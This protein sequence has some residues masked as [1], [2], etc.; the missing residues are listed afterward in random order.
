MAKRYLL[1][2]D[3]SVMIHPWKTQ[4]MMLNW[5]SLSAKFSKSVHMNT[6]K[7]P[8]VVVLTVLYM[9]TRIGYRPNF[10]VLT[11]SVFPLLRTL[12]PKSQYQM[13]PGLNTHAQDKSKGFAKFLNL[14]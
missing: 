3:N 7:N 11:F 12:P 14:F 6:F 2:L 13:R 5:V 4:C 8:N 10:V 1:K 9:L